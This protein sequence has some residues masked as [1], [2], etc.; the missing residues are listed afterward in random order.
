MRLGTSRK[1]QPPTRWPRRLLRTS[2]VPPAVVARKAIVERLGCPVKT[3]SLVL[4]AALA[5]LGLQE[6]PAI[7]ALPASQA[8]LDQQAL[9]DPWDR[10]ALSA[11]LV[12]PARLAR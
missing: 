7:R 11:L 9:P 1:P 6:L 8:R 2:R 4:R 5:P 12:K 3:V 10:L